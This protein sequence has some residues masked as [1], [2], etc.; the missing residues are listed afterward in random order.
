MKPLTGT[1]AVH[2]VAVGFIPSTKYL[3]KQN[4]QDNHDY[5]QHDDH[6]MKKKVVAQAK[7]SILSA[8]KP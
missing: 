7:S 6:I 1:H 5:H 4:K 3:S 2:V 8:V